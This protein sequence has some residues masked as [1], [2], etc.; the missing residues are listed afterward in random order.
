MT[1]AELIR[2]LAKRNGIPDSETKIF[3]ELF[4]QKASTSLKRGE[5]VKLSGIGYFQLRQGIIREIFAGTDEA[6]IYADLMVFFPMR[7]DDVNSDESLIFNVP[8]PKV[9][10]YNEVDSYFSLSIGKPVIPLEGVNDSEYFSPPSGHEL[11]KLIE[12]KVDKF[13]RSAEIINK[14]IKGNE[15]LMIEPERFSN[16]QFEFEWVDKKDN[17]VPDSGDQNPHPDQGDKTE[18]E[19]TAW[20]FGEDLSKEIEEEAIIDSAI[21]SETITDNLDNESDL[22]WNFG[23][24][25]SYEEYQDTGNTGMEDSGNEYDGAGA[26][27]PSS[28]EIK[29]IENPELNKFERVKSIVSGMEEEGESLAGIPGIE[30]EKNA[31][32]E[33]IPGKSEGNTED[34]YSS[35]P[36]TEKEKDV[37]TG[38]NEFSGKKSEEISGSSS[39]EKEIIGESVQT[40]KR[41]NIRDKGRGKNY[42]KRNT[43][44][45]FIAALSTI[46]VIGIALF[47][48]LR[49]N[50]QAVSGT[51]ANKQSGAVV[52]ASTPAVVER[53]YRIPVTYPYPPQGNK[54]ESNETGGGKTGAKNPEVEN[55]GGGAGSAN[56]EGKKGNDNHVATTLSA[57]PRKSIET[58]KIM[59][60]IS[61]TGSGYLVQVSS[62]Q[63]ETVAKK[64]AQ[65]FKEKGYQSFIDKVD[66]KGRG[67]WYRVKIGYFKTL[68]AAQQFFNRNH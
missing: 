1:K 39:E 58:P 22:E 32:G 16:D 49:K 46:I 43:S 33:T 42:S 19:H 52:N 13:F 67:T 44:A 64:E 25:D 66:L 51:S 55:N 65:K 4:L 6:L 68:I 48:F 29:E 27:E 59:D 45:V 35:M 37:E 24:P 17:F 3:F 26:E 61:R 23:T 8:V 20:N 56:G 38:R 34:R 40:D 41:N 5:A 14:Y 11:K 36:D 7:N 63:S 30:P 2:K 21:E 47:L 50:I 60:Y 28:A 53:S 15:V 31:G 57:S 18:L 62:W 10:E 54:A 9:D 12:S